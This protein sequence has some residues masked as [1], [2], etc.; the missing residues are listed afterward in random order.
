MATSVTS[1]LLFLHLCL[2]GSRGQRSDDL[3]VATLQGRVQG[4]RL[5]VLGH[6][7][8]AFLGIPYAK[9]PL[10][11]LRF[12]PPQPA[13][14]WEGVKNA[15]QFPN[16]CYQVRDTAYPGFRGAEMWNPNTL[17]SE[18]CLYLNIWT[19]SLEAKQRALPVLVWIYGGGFTS[20]TS[21]LDLY[22]G[23]FLSQSENVVVV[24][25][26]YRQGQSLLDQQLA[27]R[28]VADNIV[29]FGGNASEVTL[30]GESAG[31]ASVGYHLL[32]PGSSGLFRR[33]VLQSASPTASWASISHAEAWNRTL[34]L[35]SLLGCPLS[36][37]A[38]LER[39]LQR[40]DPEDIVTLQHQ[41]FTQ[42]SLLAIP[43]L[44]LVDDN[45]LPDDP[46][47]LLETGHFNRTEVLVGL[48]KN[49]GSYFL[50]YG[51]PGYNL[52]GQSL[53]SRKRF[54]E[55]IP[56][57]L[58]GSSHAAK[59]AAVFQ[60][61]NWSDVEDELK[62]RDAMGDLVGDLFFNCPSL[63]FAR[64]YSQR[65]GKAFV[66]LFDHRSSANPWPAWM[67]VMHGYEIEFVF[68]M[69][70]DA[71]L[72][73]TQREVNMSRTIMKHWANFARTGSPSLSGAPWPL[74]EAE[75]QIYVT[76][77][78]DPLLLKSRMI[79]QRCQF[80]TDLLPKIQ[81]VSADLEACVESSG[82]LS[83]SCMFPIAL[84]TAVMMVL[85]TFT[86]RIA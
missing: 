71:S 12:R 30:F 7:T 45:F 18:D 68:G 67:G 48:N 55:G 47:V 65:G 83:C 78:T 58:P 27:L 4:T 10:G 84:T 17:V 44:P 6:D 9:P 76:L 31:A 11:E 85:L 8:R 14:G 41:V 5:W 33:A 81:R 37:A 53:I 32:S 69:P 49:E 50:L 77:N 28:W 86:W 66:Y 62:N 73:Y 64:R 60:Y 34:I 82:T 35:A 3:S 75:S 20:G 57:V 21:S 1:L 42:P 43:F 52:T 25:M 80:C 23:R 2:S 29:F 79:A 24:S 51:V 38:D 39:C 15:A 40:A 26:N 59:E 46:E 72:N 22:D 13:D 54:L 70:L 63:D 16:T 61:T 36:P 19:P 74:F 56:L